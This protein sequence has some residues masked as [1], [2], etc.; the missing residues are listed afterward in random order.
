M[1]E[2]GQGKKI[3]SLDIKG[4][5]QSRTA[6][7]ILI[8]LIGIAVMLAIFVAA[9][10]PVRYDLRVGTVP[11]VT[12][13]ATKD[14]EDEISTENKR[15]QAANSV[16]PT[17]R[18]Q[19]G[20]TEEVMSHFDEIFDELRLVMKYGDT[21]P[22]QGP[23]RT[24]TKDELDYAR[25]LLTMVTLRDYQ[26]NSLLHSTHEE[27]E[28]A[29][30]LLY[31]ALQST[32]Q[33]HVTEGQENSSVSNIRQIVS[34]RM[35]L[36]L[37]QNVAPAVL[38]GCIRPNMLIDQEATEAA[39]E[40]ARQGVEPVVYK[41]GQNIV[42]RGE[43][44]ITANQLAMLSALGLLSGGEVDV[45]MYLGAAIL[46]LIVMTAALLLLHKPE[47]QVFSENKRLILLLLILCVSLG[48]CALS[49]LLNA[50]LAPVILSAMLVTALMGVK[51]GMI[52]NA[53]V[54]VMVAALAAGGS[55]AYTDK[56]VILLLTGLLSGTA[57]TLVIGTKP[58]KLRLLLAGLTA[59][60]L[61]FLS[62]TALGLMT[63]NQ[64]SG[65]LS[66]A[67]M[68][69][70]GS[71]AAMLICIGLQPLLESLFNLPT[72]TRLLE[73]SNPNQPLLRRLLL[74]APGTYHHSI[75][76]ANLAEAA[77]QA[78]D[79]NPLLARVGGYYHDVGKL[80]RPSYFKENQLPDQNAHDHTDPRVSAEILTAHTTDGVAL[81]KEYRLPHEVL[82]II[83]EHHG[84]TPVMFFYHKALQLSDG[85]PVD[86][87]D[88]R[89][90][91]HPPKTKEGAIVLLCDTIEAAIR[92][93][94]NPTPES[95]EEFIIKL[96]RGKLEDGQ[97]SDSPLT[98]RDIDK[99]CAAATTVLTGV[100]HER[101]EYPEMKGSDQQRIIHQ[102]QKNEEKKENT[103][104]A[105]VEAS[106]TD[107]KEEK[108]PATEMPEQEE[109]KPVSQAAAD[110]VQIP[111]V[112]PQAPEEIEIVT[113]PPVSVPVTI[114][115]AA[116]VQEEAMQPVQVM[117]ENE[118][119]QDSLQPENKDQPEE[120]K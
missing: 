95:M 25:S 41:Q 112:L 9:I 55:E 61:D 37:S 68:R 18:Y 2:R 118:A 100:F 85:S 93:L 53:A 98:L 5:F 70:G 67:A 14:V 69:A 66:I 76:V 72:A 30:T 11:S 15:E 62:V 35:S 108:L 97:L 7:Q 59:C 16:T 80:V 74:E 54:S 113:P 50:Y 40:A 107:R 56:M 36:P 86:I 33:G 47:Y 111:V 58:S 19:D 21:L 31:T 77:A 102:D 24:Y 89:Y 105:P 94:K 115:E 8:C 4:F 81:G 65:M 57:A 45:S 49:G 43:G 114:E 29:Y 91:A 96:V 12:I 38:N 20:I 51:P 119:A 110:N 88:F 6:V 32:M 13:A 48:V 27:L 92:T 116:A 79:A 75:I 46:V 28:D 63:A 106:E 3:R 39:R 90:D 34:Y 64:L 87:N 26:L 71:L 104:P 83:A 1:R 84:D 44:R 52:A 117:P 10:V 99:I 60:A 78:V 17:Y 101:I 42:V 103:A 120:T 109:A 82:S 22:E 73:L 23:A